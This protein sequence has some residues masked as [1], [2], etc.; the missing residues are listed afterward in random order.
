MAD[1]FGRLENLAAATPE[2]MLEALSMLIDG[3]AQGTEWT[4]EELQRL[5]ELEEHLAD[6]VAGKKNG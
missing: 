3:I 6:V 1:L 4:G 2:M 5:G